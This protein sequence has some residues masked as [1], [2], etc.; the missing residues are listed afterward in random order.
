MGTHPD[1]QAFGRRRGGVSVGAMIGLSLLL[2]IPAYALSRFAAFVDWRLI[3]GAPLTL[4]LLT[5]LAYRSDKHRAEFGEWRIPESTLHIAELVGGWP[6]AF[7][8]QRTFRH[9]ISKTS[10]QVEFWIIV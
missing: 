6:G 7:L 3:A 8:A 10:Y 5:F 9:K 1:E 2:V 4:S